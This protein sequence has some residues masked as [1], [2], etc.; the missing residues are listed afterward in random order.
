MYFIS[1]V[2]VRQIEDE[3]S[4]NSS[5]QVNKRINTKSTVLSQ[6]NSKMYAL[7]PTAFRKEASAA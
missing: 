1:L 4:R 5:T 3:I 2:M 6:A 7:A